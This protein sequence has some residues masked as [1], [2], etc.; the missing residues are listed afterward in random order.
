[1]RVHLDYSFL[2]SVLGFSVQG[3]YAATRDSPVKDHNSVKGVGIFP[4]WGK[5]EWN[6]FWLWDEWALAQVTHRSCGISIPGAFKCR[7]GM[8]LTLLQVTLFKLQIVRQDDFQRYPYS[9]NH[10]VVL[11]FQEKQRTTL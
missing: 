5:T 9:L 10:S 8:V 6:I 1:M 11:W 2:H 3:G 7:L 4:M